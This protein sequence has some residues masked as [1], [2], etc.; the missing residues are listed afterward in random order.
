MLFK[1][2][3]IDEA[4]HRRRARVSAR[5]SQDA[6]DQ[7]ERVY[8]ESR[9]GACVRMVAVPVLHVVGRANAPARAYS[10]G[11]SCGL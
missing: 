10:R 7:M 6:H 1:V 4:G 5:S 11:L 9:A 3:H 2:T 8:G